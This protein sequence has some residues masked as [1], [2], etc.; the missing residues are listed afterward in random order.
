MKPI[1]HL[2]QGKIW[3]LEGLVIHL[4]LLVHL[5]YACVLL[6]EI[7]DLLKGPAVGLLAYSLPLIISQLRYTCVFHHEKTRN[8]WSI[9]SSLSLELFII[10]PSF[11][12]ENL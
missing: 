9:L 6:K 4:S 10:T 1:F 12:F 8:E 2:L 3:R 7:G 11:V 5:T